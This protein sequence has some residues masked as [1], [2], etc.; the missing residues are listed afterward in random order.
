MKSL[1]IIFAALSSIEFVRSE[2]NLWTLEADD[3]GANSA[4]SCLQ[5]K[6]R[7]IS[8]MRFT[9]TQ[10]SGGNLNA[11]LDGICEEDSYTPSLL[12]QYFSANVL[13]WTANATIMCSRLGAQRFEWLQE[14]VN[15]TEDGITESGSRIFSQM[16]KRGQ[17]PQLLE[18]L[19]GILRDPTFVCDG[20]DFGKEFSIDWLVLAN[21]GEAVSSEAKSILYDA[22]GTRFM[23]AM[24]FF[25]S[26][27][28]QRGITFDQIYVWEAVAQGLEA[29]WEGTPPEVRSKWESR[30]TF[31][32]GV[33][34]SSDP[35]HEHNPPN[36]IL[37]DC[38]PED[39]CAFK[40]DIDTPSVELPIV[41][42]LMDSPQ[43]GDVLDEFFFE[44]HVAGLMQLYGWGDDV[45]GTFAD[46]YAIFEGLRKMGI[47][48]HSWI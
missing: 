39:F 36:R 45:N 13:D 16:C 2:D 26:K 42:Q 11:N 1:S 25:V 6:S 28:E 24:H 10:G 17:P 43:F 41:Q 21:R 12:E 29:Y 32:D 9:P 34:C 15:A 22:G 35:N 46:S 19:A 47:R 31:Y 48:A 7:E 5:V 14:N 30:L 8:R 20:I 27:Y 3:H 44:H 4:L 33:P 40:L 18:P 38:R 37:R 23:D